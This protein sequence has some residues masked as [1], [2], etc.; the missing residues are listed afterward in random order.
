MDQT[1][2][3]GRVAVLDR[4]EQGRRVLRAIREL[5][6]AGRAEAAIAVVARGERE[7]PFAREADEVVFDEGGPERALRAARARAAWLGAATPP[8]RA[9]FAAACA[10]AGVVPLGWP[11]A[12]LAR[13]AEPDQLAALA[14][15]LGVEVAA[16]APEPRARRLEVVVA[17]DAAGGAQ[18]LA[19]ADVSLRRGPVTVLS[20]SPAPGLG[21]DLDQAVRAIAL[22]AA[23]A[24]G[25]VG[26]AAVELLLDR[27]SGVLALAG[28]D[29]AP[30]S[31]AAVEAA[32]A[33][34]LIRLALHLALGGTLAAAIPSGGHAVA[35]RI[36]ARDPEAAASAAPGRVALLRLPTDPDVRA[37]AAAEEGDPAP[38]DAPVAMVVARGPD[39]DAARRR[40]VQALADSDVLVS[41]T[42][43]S[44]AWL[45]ALL[46]HPEVRAGEAGAGFLAGL[47][48]GGAR[49]VVPRPGHA[50]L[51][52]AIEAYEA[53]LDLERA[54]FL[55]EARR[56]R[57]RVGPSAGRA[58]DLRLAGRRHRLE[59]RQ[60]APDAFRVVS[61]ASTIDV[62]VERLGAGERRLD[63]G[64]RRV[65][66][67]SVADGARRLVDVEGVPHV[68]DREPSG[69]VVCPLPAVVVALPVAPGQRVSKG[70]P[71]A[72][73]ESMK[74]ELVVQAPED[75]IVRELLTNPNAQVDAG[76]PLLRLEP[77]G[78]APLEAGPPLAFDPPARAP[79]AADYLGGL[80]E[81]RGVL[82][83]FDVAPAE[84]RRL[85]AALAERAAGVP[86]EDPASL[87]AEE[88]ALAAFADLLVLFRRAKEPGAGEG[89]R[90]PLEELWRYL[91]EPEA[92]GAGLSSQFVSLLRSALGHY[93]VSLDA[94]GRELEIALLRIQK[95]HER[96]DLSL[97]PVLAILERR[98]GAGAAPPGLEG[99]GARALL[100]RLAD[101]GQERS[102]AVADLARDL[103]YR[104]FD[105]PAFE[106]IRAD[107]YAQAEADL[108]AVARPGAQRDEALARLVACPQPL[109]TLLI[110]RMAAADPPV[111][112]ALVET[113]LRRYYRIRSLRS[114]ATREVDGL[115]CATA[116]YELDGRRIRL[117]AGFAHAPDAPR[118][119]RALARLG[120]EL[121]GDADL[122]LEA[123]LWSDAPAE[124]S[125]ASA[126]PLR[127]ALA[128]A[129]FTRPLRRASFVVARAGRGLGRQASQEH[130]SFRGGPTEFTDEPRYG[131]VH[132][133]LF[134]RMGL[135][136]LSKFDL[137]RLPSVEDVFLYRGVARGNA[138]DE[139]LFAVAEV[140]DLT[141]VRDAQGRVVQLPHL[142]RMLH[143]ALAGM[144]RFQAGRP[145]HQRLEWN[146]VLLTLEPPFLLSRDEIHR[147][148][149]RLRPATEGLGLE[150]VLLAARVPDPR[151]GALEDTLV[152]VTMTGQ[153]LSVRY[154]APTYRPL[155]PLEEY[156]QRVIAL[157][158]RGLTHPFEIVRMLAPPR[159]AQ[160]DVPPGEFVEHDLDE[161]FALAPVSRPP[162]RNVANMVA[163]VVKTFTDRYPEGMQRVVLL[164]D[165]TKAMGSLAEPECRRIAAAIDLAEKLRVPLEWFA[166]SAGAKISMESGTENMD[167]ISRVLRRIIEFT[168]RGGEI[169]VVVTGINVG[170]QPYWNAEAT[171]LMHTRGILVMTP[172]S[173]MVLTGK[174]ALE[175]SGSVAAEDNLGIGGYDRIMGPNGQA[176]YQAGSLADGIRILLAHYEHTYVAPGERFPRRARTADPTDRDVR[177]SP[178][179]PEGGA[180]FVTVGD[181]FS[182]DKNPDRKKPFDIRRVMAAAI[183][184]DH[185]PLERWRDVRGGE[186]AVVWDAHL[187]G[188]PVCL[189]GIES[190][191]LPR[192]EFVPADGPELWSAGTLFPQ[193]SKKIARAINGA[194]ANR[195][196]VVLANLSGFDGSPES[197]RRLQLEYGAE[198]GRA[199]VNFEGP[200][201][202]CVVSRYHGGAFV[203]F[204][205]TLRDDM[206]AV[207]VEGARAS[208]IGG[209]PAAAVVFAREVETRARKDPRVVEAEQAIAQGGGPA[210]TR[211]GELLTQVRS[212]KVGEVAEEFDVVHTVERARRV[213]SLDDIIAAQELRP[214]L[215][216]AVERGIARHGGAKK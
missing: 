78:E 193:S 42:G 103:R 27:A 208:V 52:A 158:R 38:A 152:R 4:G 72:R 138:K 129:G 139:R 174:E 197:M 147:L 64:G 190:R 37:E 173:A 156:Q 70:D 205:K 202:F 165:P 135:V 43:T 67:L 151:T 143:E 153:G 214:W 60:V 206:E 166:V 171:M 149:V 88:D 162:G 30:A 212:E 169:N 209:A 90:P 89:A 137:Q 142:E 119:T 95:A 115:A 59:V 122:T 32:A 194:S 144:R 167:W 55:A 106:R 31:A 204:S 184:R 105:R 75:G 172:G 6:R 81:L 154:D 177:A 185:P 93:G 1:S 74:V 117:V 82:L 160:A 195:P 108:A 150:M 123:Y 199:V 49:L 133:L 28:V 23:A 157:R 87:R 25:I 12:A 58:V 161:S 10:A 215:V 186:T 63:V 62:R 198:I 19:T 41:G 114:V 127:A 17:R 68:V 140:R 46:E 107:A 99:D 79:A 11:S 83:G 188:W 3:V 170:A 77:A 85:A 168:Q 176:Q 57:P 16:R 98:L 5:A 15:E 112:P 148:A 33:V 56:G 118:L 187:G 53:D 211:L 97:P 100:D 45:I 120:E 181:V 102:A 189:L 203:V 36:E 94:P 39:R 76:A 66:V 132:P 131:G 86:V 80:A 92:R 101:V 2:S 73:V 104:R 29:P 113:L 201:V 26:V 69:L 116:E 180:G 145:P 54:R 164:G 22:K 8:A 128:G 182:A 40:L 111:R 47:A 183:D 125:D 216:A 175:Y 21:R 124:P 14:A 210:R 155:E 35:A 71:V 213:G 13:L 179:G 7:S 91:H 126:G 61:G 163:G 48:A 51:A 141:P 207:A 24:A 34:D 20:E 44:R 9:A 130:L 65:R 159:G 191:P 146:R 18:A 136:R 200:L 50:L 96:A 192:L 84:A 196:V 110:A 178:H 121:A 109:A 134:R